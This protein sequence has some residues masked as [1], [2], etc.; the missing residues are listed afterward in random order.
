MNGV[1]KLIQ[2]KYLK[3]CAFTIF[4]IIVIHG[5]YAR[6]E[7][8]SIKPISVLKFTGGVISA[9]LIHEGAHALVAGVTDTDMTWEFGNYNQ[10]IAFTEESDSDAAGLAVNAAGLTAQAIGSEIILQVDAIDKNDAYVRGMMTWNII[11]PIL[12]ALDYWFI[13]ISNESS[14]NS[15]QGDLEGIEFYSNETVGNVA[16][17][18]FASIALFQGYRFLKTQTWAPDWITNEQHNLNLTKIPDGGLLLSY[19]IQF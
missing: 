19:R 6:C 2:L 12:Y 15:Y 1:C 13:G 9:F 17:I 7:E 11:N 14:D 18:S 4:A 16:A 8:D 3:I 10:P 5:N